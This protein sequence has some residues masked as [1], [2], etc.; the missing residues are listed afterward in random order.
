MLQQST[1]TILS[2]SAASLAQGIYHKSTGPIGEWTGQ[3]GPGQGRLPFYSFVVVQQSSQ[4]RF[5]FETWYKGSAL[6]LKI[7]LLEQIE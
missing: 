7:G 6:V 2:A 5:A 4:I 1:K 3:A